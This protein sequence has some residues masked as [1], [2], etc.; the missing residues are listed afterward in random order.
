[1][2]PNYSALF[3]CPHGGSALVNRGGVLVKSSKLFLISMLILSWLTLP[4]LGKNAL[5]KFLPAG[6]FICVLTKFLDKFGER[7]KW[8]HFYKAISPL[9][10]MD[11]FNF[12]PYLAT[13]L[14]MLKLFYGKF[15]AFL[16]SNTILQIVFIYFGL[17]Y[18][19]R[20]RILSLV[21]LTK[22]QYLVIDI[23]RA[24]LLYFFQWAKDKLTI[25]IKDIQIKKTPFNE[26]NS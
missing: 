25:F 8:W 16:V 7:K 23:F 3:N 12:G 19:K 11:F 22:F 20:F 5:K 6:L 1:V 18:V 10:S 9:D 14:W 24:I 17:K 21:F 2:P 4:L 26:G 13:S 15:W